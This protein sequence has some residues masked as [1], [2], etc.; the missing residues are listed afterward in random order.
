MFIFNDALSTF[1]LWLYG[2]EHGKRP[3]R[4]LERKPAAGTIWATI[5]D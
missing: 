2:V 3:L 1:Y 4:Q 5:F